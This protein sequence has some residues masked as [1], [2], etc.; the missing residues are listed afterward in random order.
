MAIRGERV[1]E[2]GPK[3]VLLAG[4]SR[5]S[6]EKSRLVRLPPLG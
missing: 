2:I 1:K 3:L 6:A 4:K 5:F